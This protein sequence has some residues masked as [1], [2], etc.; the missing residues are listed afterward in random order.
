[1]IVSLLFTIFQLHWNGLAYKRLSQITFFYMR[2][3]PHKIFIRTEL[4]IDFS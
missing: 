4:A 1:L 2:L 3:I